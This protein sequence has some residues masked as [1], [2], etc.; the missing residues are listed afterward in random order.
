MRGAGRLY[1]NA[2]FRGRPVSGVER[3]AVEMLRQ[4]R[5]PL[6]EIAPRPHAD[7]FAGH[8]WEQFVLPRLV[9]AGALWSPANTGP[10]AVARQALT[11][12]DLGPLD[13]PGWYRP[14]FAAWYR[15]LWPRLVDRVRVILADSN[16]TRSRIIARLGL[17]GDR[18]RV[19][20]VGVDPL[21]FSPRPAGEIEALRRRYGLP[22]RYVL[23]VGT[24]Q[25]RKNLAGLLRAHEI[26]S[27]TYPDVGLAVSGDAGPQF[28][29]QA[30][31]AGS[32]VYF[33]GRV[34]GDDLP[35]LYSGAQVF[36]QPSFY[37]GAGLTVLEA[38]G[39][40]CP[41]AAARGSALEEYLGAAG[42]IFDPAEPTEIAAAVRPI[43]ADPDLREQLK[44]A[45]IERAREYSWAR[46]AE[47]V[48]VILESIRRPGSP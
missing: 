40:G 20:R 29:K 24:L 12:H 8:L 35:A 42:P 4:F 34:S 45:G 41:V 22:K 23:F 46:R 16:F 39:C 26:T 25:P 6:I 10:L 30:Q 5:M 48:E 1:V 17:S 2:R 3:Y 32:G 19:V 47:T 13:H 37:E 44:Q 18:V 15:W 14:T 28:V 43:L 9:G 38:L 36:V 27:G 11:I 7:G 33:L 21:R 31:P